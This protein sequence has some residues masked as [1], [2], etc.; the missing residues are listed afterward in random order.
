MY[1]FQFTVG[2]DD[3]IVDGWTEAVGDNMVL[4]FIVPK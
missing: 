3:G 4:F 1:V 2:S